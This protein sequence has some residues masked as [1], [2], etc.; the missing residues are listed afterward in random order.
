MSDWVDV[1]KSDQLA[2]GEHTVIDIDDVEVAVFNIEG[3]IYAI[4]DLCS[5]DNYPIADGDLEGDTIACPAHGA[6]FCIRTGEALSAPATEAIPVFPV[7]IVDGMI[8]VR[9]DRN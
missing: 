3:E 8:Q 2:P 5:H 1:V 6:E 9:D 4:E 7:R